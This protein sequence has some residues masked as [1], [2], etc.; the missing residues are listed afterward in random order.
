MFDS[1]QRMV[2]W[3]MVRP[4]PSQ[5]R[6][7]GLEGDLIRKHARVDKGCEI[8]FRTPLT[9]KLSSKETI[10][11]WNVFVFASEAVFQWSRL[12]LFYV[13]KRFLIRKRSAS[14]V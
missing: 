8:D 7:I 12:F 3:S 10:K 1:I 4:T 2:Q 11:L 5:F 6:P 9:G 13:K 14:Y